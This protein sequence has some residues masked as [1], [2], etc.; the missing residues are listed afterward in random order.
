MRFFISVSDLEH[1]TGASGISAS[2]GD[3]LDSR[4]REI[5][6][7]LPDDTEFSVDESG[8][9][10]VEVPEPGDDNKKTAARHAEKVSRAAGNGDY[11]KAKKLFLKALDLDPTLTAARRDLAM[12]CSEI[13]D[14]EAAK[15]NLIDVLRVTPD[16][17]W[18]YVILANHYSKA[19]NNPKMAATLLER[20]VEIAPDDPYVHNSL[21]AA[22]L[23]QDREEEAL[24][25]FDLALSANPR[26]A[27]AHYGQAMV[28]VRQQDFPRAEA[29]FEALFHQSTHDDARAAAMLQEARSTFI[30]IE[31]IIANNRQEESL[32]AVTDLRR[33]TEELSG[34]PVKETPGQLPQHIGARIRMA[35]KHG[36]DHHQLIL[37]SGDFPEIL[38]HHLQAHELYHVILESAARRRG[39]NKWFTASNHER[40]A[41]REV[42]AGPLATLGRKG[43]DSDALDQLFTQVFDGITNLLYN[44]PIDMR[45]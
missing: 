7:F 15:D 25:H 20:A 19:E 35:W 34:Y 29:A 18:S 1:L 8:V 31:N 39:A 6:Y 40:T 10:Q 41:A 16:D 23:E 2:S 21:A 28:Y 3:G 45:I 12:L 42:L 33:K 36:L 9:V 37:R 14:H 26:F 43:F 5:F 17:A 30:K 44:C 11:S 22:H 4:L 32:R 27:N 24:R 38:K 13:G